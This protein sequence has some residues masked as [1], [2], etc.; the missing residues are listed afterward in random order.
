MIYTKKQIREQVTM[1][2]DTRGFEDACFLIIEGLS[3]L[4]EAGVEEYD[5]TDDEVL[6]MMEW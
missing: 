4:D 3:L 6:E 2:L 1:L 5:F